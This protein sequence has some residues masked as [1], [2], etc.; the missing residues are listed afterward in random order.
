MF[1]T[2][3]CNHRIEA[4][5]YTPKTGFVLGICLYILRV[6]VIKIIIII[7]IIY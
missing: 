3:N 4:Q 5:L 1:S 7:V 6:D 2:K